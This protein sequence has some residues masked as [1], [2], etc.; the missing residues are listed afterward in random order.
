[1]I[2][3]FI[4][5]LFSIE[6]TKKQLEDLFVFLLEE[7]TYHNFAI[8][9]ARNH[10]TKYVNISNVNLI[11]FIVKVD[12]SQIENLLS[13]IE[14]S[15]KQELYELRDFL[16]SRPEVFKKIQL[17]REENKGLVDF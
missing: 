15:S 10:S 17:Y 6:F 1:M 2:P 5:D 14:I 13:K 11:A 16:F 9:F 12:E 4:A 3:F 8:E 7:D